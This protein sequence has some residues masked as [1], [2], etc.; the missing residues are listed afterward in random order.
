MCPGA[1]TAVCAEGGERGCEGCRPARCQR[2]RAARYPRRRR[3]SKHSAVSL[4]C[5]GSV[6]RQAAVGVQMYDVQ[7]SDFRVERESWDDTPLVYTTKHASRHPGNDPP[8]PRTFRSPPVSL[9]LRSPMNPTPLPPLPVPRCLTRS[10][11]HPSP[12]PHCTTQ[13]HTG[14][15]LLP[16]SPQPPPAPLHTFTRLFVAPLGATRQPQLCVAATIFVV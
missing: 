14:S 8:C 4:G 9:P 6:T 12:H 3:A 15:P 13:T 2:G 7:C 16:L 11:P 10:L 1:V 5:V